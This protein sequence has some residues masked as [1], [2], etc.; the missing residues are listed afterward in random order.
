MSG[1]WVS[2][3]VGAEPSPAFLIL[4]SVDE[5]G[6]KSAGAAAMATA[7]AE[8]AADTTVPRSSSAG[9]APPPCRGRDPALLPPGVGGQ[10]EADAAEGRAGERVAETQGQG[11]PLEARR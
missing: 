9:A 1:V 2:S 11:H 4:V 5:T 7:S 8:T 10:V 6:R 3:S